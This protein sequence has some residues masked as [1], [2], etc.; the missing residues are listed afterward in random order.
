M[1]QP[2]LEYEK[3]GK[4]RKHQPSPVDDGEKY[5]AVYFTRFREKCSVR[6]S[7]EKSILQKDHGY[8]LRKVYCFKFEPLIWDVEKIK[9]HSVAVLISDRGIDCREYNNIEMDNDWDCCSMHSWLNSEFYENAFEDSEKKIF[10]R[11]ESAPGDKVFLM[12]RDDDRMFVDRH[13][14]IAGS[15]YYKCLGGMG[16]RCI[17]NCWITDKSLDH[18]GEASVI[19]P[20]TRYSLDRVQVD[21]TSVA[22]LPKVYITLE[23]GDEKRFSNNK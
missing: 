4:G 2:F 5:R 16:D 9:S 18:N 19:Y 23:S 14:S 7:R 21:N 10:C 6:E 11:F 17:S 1:R 15:D 13:N 12:D 22:V 3:R 20:T 8:V